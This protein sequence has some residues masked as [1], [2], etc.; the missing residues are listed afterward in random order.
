MS[1]LES[2]LTQVVVSIEMALQSKMY[3]PALILTYSGIDTAGWLAS[4]D[5]SERVGTRFCRWVDLWLLRAKPLRCTSTDLYAARCGILHTFTSD[6][7]F[8]VSGR[9]RRICY[10]SGVRT[11]QDLQARL[12][13]LGRVDCIALHFDELFVGFRLGLADY[14]EHALSD[15]AESAQLARKA[16]RYFTAITGDEADQFGQPSP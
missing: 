9:A 11:S 5:P 10:A 2:S 16:E 4:A 13:A 15:P 8:S 14:F 12:D 3:L 6:S 7:D 1:P